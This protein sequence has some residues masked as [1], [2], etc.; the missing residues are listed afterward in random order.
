MTAGHHD[1]KTNDYIAMLERDLL[2]LPGQPYSRCAIC[3]RL[4]LTH[5]MREN[6]YIAARFHCC[7]CEECTA[8]VDRLCAYYYND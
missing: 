3:G 5:N 8:A 1:D 4:G 6:T 2:E 7:D